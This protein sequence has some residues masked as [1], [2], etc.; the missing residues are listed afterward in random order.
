MYVYV[1]VHVCM[2]VLPVYVGNQGRLKCVGLEE[3]ILAC[4]LD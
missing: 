4:C 1:C 2:C 3:T